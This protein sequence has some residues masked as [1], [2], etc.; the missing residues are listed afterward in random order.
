MIISQGK[1]PLDKLTRRECL[2]NFC[3]L[4]EPDCRGCKIDEALDELVI[5]S[6]SCKKLSLQPKTGKIGTPAPQH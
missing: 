3:T 4:S 6:P 5:I 1:K 2:G